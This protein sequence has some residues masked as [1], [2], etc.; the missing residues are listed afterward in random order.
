MTSAQIRQ[1]FLNFFKERDHKVLPSSSLIPFGDPTLLFTSAGMVQFKPYF[2]GQA[3]PATA[4]AA[5]SQKVF[6]TSDVELVGHDGHHLTFFEMLGNFSFGDYFKEKAIP[7]AYEFLTRELRLDESRLWAGIHNDDDESFAIWVNQT[8]IPAERVRRFG[9]DYNFWAA[10]PTGP[11]GPDSEVHYDWGAEYGCGRPDCGPNCEYCDRF[12]EIWNLV[13]MQWDRD[14]AGNRTPLERKGIDTGMGLERI[15]AVVNGTRAGVFETDVFRPL[16][17]HWVKQTGQPYGTRSEP[18]VSIRVLADHARGSTMLLADGVMPSNEGR[19]Y[20]LRRLIRRAMVHA[21]RL[22]GEARLSSAVPVVAGT[23]GDVYPEVRSNAARIAEAI[24][25]EEERFSIALRQ[26]MERLQGLIERKALTAEEVFYLHDTL[27]FPVELSAELALEQGVNVDMTAVAGLMQVQRDK[28]RSA[29]AE[30]TAPL[31]KTRS[32]FVGYDQLEADARVA[33]SVPVDEEHADVYLDLTPFYAERGGQTAD[34]GWLSGA[35]SQRVDVLDVQ[36]VGEAIRHRV[37]GRE[38]GWLRAGQPVHASVD[39]DRRQA[40][41]RH[42]SATH[43]LHRALRDV[44]GDQASQ[45]GSS[46]QPASATFDFRFPRALTRPELEHV[47]H[48]LNEKIRANLERR[49]EE[50]PLAE[51]IASGAV[52][53]FDEKYG[54]TVRVV[55]FGD[56]ARELCG[57]THVGRTGEIGLAMIGTDRSVA[58]GVR[59]IELRAGRAAEDLVLGHEEAL[60]RISDS[61]RA[62]ATD[63]PGRVESIQNEVKRLQKEVS[64]LRQRLAAG[65]QAQLVEADVEGIRLMLQR[66]E[67]APEELLGFA[68][69]ALN[70]G[71]GNA[72]AIVVGGR[73]LAV[74]V[75]APLADRLPA[76]PLVQAFQAVAGGKGG[77]RGAV[78]QG[79]GL[80]PSRVDEAFKSV[81]TY[82]RERLR[83]S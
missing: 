54:D 14:Q 49:V 71:N 52:A 27:G 21:R 3:K 18:D 33:E 60:N 70:R 32:R 53:L 20:V 10:G 44:L 26:G 72:V 22:G 4:R 12:L 46:V 63:L 19:G 65:G 15:T 62:G 41:A 73:S 47:S 13:F 29:S 64:A 38:L 81:Q 42:H 51:A 82:V 68:D 39:S 37:A 61:L 78:G 23:L 69:H 8:G 48:R 16:I 24:S 6:R 36:A 30:F 1:R 79:G 66:V 7:Y 58:A 43:L 50:L 83:R 59:R 31:S 9:D 57:G 80:D 28:S 76:G 25:S 40:V 5:T 34:H 67:A 45:A 75:A 56:W 11:C 74:K 2:L 17:E 35:D 55:S 77:G